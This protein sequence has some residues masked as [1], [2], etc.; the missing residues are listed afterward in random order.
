MSDEN[1]VPYRKPQRI[2]QRQTWW[3]VRKLLVIGTSVEDDPGMLQV[4][5]FIPEV[6]ISQR[7]YSDEQRQQQCE[8]DQS[9]LRRIPHRL[10]RPTLG[11]SSLDQEGFG[12]EWARGSK[13]S[14]KHGT[15]VDEG[16]SCAVRLSSSCWAALH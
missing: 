7:D 5:R 16:L 1:V 11:W 3:S 2:D 13:T 9:I 15:I 10:H 12:A 14:G 4:H 8:C 6:R